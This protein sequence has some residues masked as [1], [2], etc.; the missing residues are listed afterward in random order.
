MLS[1]RS[2]FAKR[3]QFPSG[4]RSSRHPVLPHSAHLPCYQLSAVQTWTLFAPIF[5]ITHSLMLFVVVVVMFRIVIRIMGGN[6][7]PLK[8]CDS[9]RKILEVDR[10]RLTRANWSF[11][12]NSKLWS[13]EIFQFKM[14]IVWKSVK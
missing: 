5:R 4:H 6:D 2:Q 14:V 12:C 11:E 8:L 3:F 9:W 1:I 13:R 7:A 10:S